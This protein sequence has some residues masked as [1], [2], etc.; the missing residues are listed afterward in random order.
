LG[1]NLLKKTTI[2][3]VQKNITILM[4]V[5]AILMIFGIL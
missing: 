2:K 4:F 1:N 3:F 5:I